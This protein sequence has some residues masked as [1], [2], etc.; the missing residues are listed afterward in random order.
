MKNK[1]SSVDLKG[2]VTESNQGLQLIVPP[3]ENEWCKVQE[4]SIEEN[5]DKP[6]RSRIIGWDTQ[7]NA[8]VIEY[9]GYNN[10]LNRTSIVR[11][12]YTGIIG[13]KIVWLMI[14]GFYTT[15]TNN[16]KDF[17]NDLG[18]TE[19]DDYYCNIEKYTMGMRG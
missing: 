16:Y 18:K 11:Y 1:I 3:S 5:I 17:V 8:C 19:I 7:N 13:G 9:S 12:G 10:C 4:L 14:D 6:A 2:M 15:E